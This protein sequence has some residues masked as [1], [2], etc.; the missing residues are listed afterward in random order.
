MVHRGCEREARL[1][2]LFL[3][4]SPNAM[5]R[6]QRIGEEGARYNLGNMRSTLGNPILGLGVLQKGYQ[7][8]FQFSLGKED[9][10]AGPGVWTVDYKETSMPAM[11]QGEAGRD[12]FAHGRRRVVPAVATSSSTPASGCPLIRAT[13]RCLVCS[14]SSTS[15]RKVSPGHAVRSPCPYH[16]T[17]CRPG[18]IAPDGAGFD[19]TGDRELLQ[20]GCPAFHGKT[21]KPAGRSL[22]A[23]SAP[24]FGPEGASQWS[25]SQ[26]PFGAEFPQD[27]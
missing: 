3:T 21:G 9:K 5:G 10:A 22:R 4:D 12:L 11:I 13:R 24:H 26:T 17:D 15:M 14:R 8:R 1:A 25:A 19:V 23:G 27:L 7:S 18:A 6:A 20:S 2:K 16:P